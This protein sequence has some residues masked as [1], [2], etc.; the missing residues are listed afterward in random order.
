MHIVPRK[1]AWAWTRWLFPAG[2]SPRRGQHSC[3][4]G[5]PSFMPKVSQWGPAT[6]QPLCSFSLHPGIG[7]VCFLCPPSFEISVYCRPCACGWSLFPVAVS[8]A[9]GSTVG[10]RLQYM[11]SSVHLCQNS[12]KDSVMVSFKAEGLSWCAMALIEA[13]K[14]S[15]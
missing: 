9:A 15:V 4:L 13:G 7:Q 11:S 1:G 10:V 8:W 2:N 5:D 14:W 3:H 12:H 6:A